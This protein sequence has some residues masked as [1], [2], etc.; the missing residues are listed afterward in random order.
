MADYSRAE[1]L[2]V[3]AMEIRKA[4]LGEQHPNYA[5]S[6]NN[7]ALLYYNMADLSR[8][9]PLYVQSMEIFKAALGEQHPEYANSLN[10]LA[11]L[12]HEMGDHSRS[13]PLFTNAINI[14]L[15]NLE[16]T[17]SV[18][19]ESQQIALSQSLRHQLDGSIICGLEMDPQPS[20]IMRQITSWK[21]SVFVRLR[22]LRLAAED[23][24]IAD[25][26]KA[27][28]SNTQ[29]LSA[30]TNTIPAP[31]KQVAW[32]EQIAELTQQK[33][34]LDA[35]LMRDSVAFRSA[36]QKVS[37]DDVRQAI[38]DDGVIV[39]YLEYGDPK[40]GRLLMATVI[41][42]DAEPVMVRLG[43][44]ADA[45]DAIR[46][47]RETLGA[48][49]A[50]RQAGLR[51]RK[52]I[53]ERLL[54][55][56]GDASLIF[57]STDGMLG[58]LPFAALPGKAEN[59]YL[60]EDHAIVM[61]PVPMLLPRMMQRP[62]SEPGLKT[63]VLMGDVDYDSAAPI[64]PTPESK[65]SPQPLLAGASLRGVRE[66]ETYPALAATGPEVDAIAKL[67]R[68]SDA[69]ADPEIISLRGRGATES[70]FRD[71]AEKTRWMH[72]ATHGFF[73]AADKKNAMAVVEADRDKSGFGMLG[74]LG[75]KPRPLVGFSPGRLSGLVFAGANQ[76]SP[77]KDVATT[78]LAA[79]NAESLDDG[80]MTADEI[81]YMQLE[82]VDLAV[83]SACETG[84]GATA[85]G[86]GI[87]GLQR[88]FQVAG[89]R[90]TVTSLWKVDDAATQALMVEFYRNLLERKLSR[91]ESLRQAQLWLLNHPEGVTGRDLTRG[92][93]RELKPIDPAATNP[94][95]PNRSLP[96]YWAAFQLS[97]DPR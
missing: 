25:T 64:T 5:G 70:V 34:K 20:P 93:V 55:H 31:E 35:Q 53:W 26:F 49:E 41:R 16:Q 13:E 83:L 52:Q 61:L 4:A 88:A 60:I 62:T 14:T 37:L 63:A 1:P 43:S 69:V 74:Q 57:V 2:Y 71:V 3:Q 17:A 51:L 90:T 44:V 68:D 59:S 75:D 7:L 86:E 27:L 45:G 77:S 33:D 91:L 18:Q 95:V 6:L 12:Y 72:L 82:N 89:A 36:Q 11:R 42:R 78:S 29:R 8:A 47:W 32:K 80:I 67:F 58:Q 46:G 87:L 19:T 38:P 23:P 92:T 22:G 28:R 40:T 30:L 97:G 65:A 73:A 50:A 48:D 15:R 79:S 9:E 66:G 54:P 24:A 94:P 96:A 85:G 56:L 84:L 10:N 21:G 81:M 39:N 76:W